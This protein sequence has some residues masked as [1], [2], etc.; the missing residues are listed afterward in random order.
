MDIWYVVWA[1]RIG[2]CDTG[3]SPLA[4]LFGAGRPGGADRPGGTIGMPGGTA[5]AEGRAG[6][7]AADRGTMGDTEGMSC[8]PTSEAALVE[9]VGDIGGSGGIDSFRRK[10]FTSGGVAGRAGRPEGAGVLGREDE[11]WDGVFVLV[12]VRSE[13]APE[14]RDSPLLVLTWPVRVGRVLPARR[15]VCRVLVEAVEVP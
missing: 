7:R 1:A 13:R 11:A 10:A 14:G 6:D 4:N 3:P 9:G 5:G 8:E 2:V 12:F 15:R